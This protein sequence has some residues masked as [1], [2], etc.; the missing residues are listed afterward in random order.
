MS[1]PKKA[2]AAQTPA[3]VD[4]ALPLAYVGTDTEVQFANHFLVQN[5]G[6]REW[7]LSVGLLAVPPLL[8]A[9]EDVKAELERKR[10]LPITLYGRYLMTR[11]RM[12]ELRD[13][14]TRQI[15]V[16]TA[17]EDEKE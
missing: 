1:T 8:G 16:S 2:T 3:F 10:F 5:Q 17:E 4:V 14:L 15:E 9:P 12:I 13:L 11:T 7:I 6:H